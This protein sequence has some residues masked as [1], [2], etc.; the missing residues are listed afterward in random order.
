MQTPTHNRFNLKH[1]YE[2]KPF[3][4]TL[5]VAARIISVNLPTNHPL[6]IFQLWPIDLL[7]TRLL[8]E[9]SSPNIRTRTSW[10]IQATDVHFTNCICPFRILSAHPYDKWIIR[11]AI[12]LVAT[13][14]ER[15][16]RRMLRVFPKTH[17]Q[18]LELPSVY[19]CRSRFR[20]WLPEAVIW[21]SCCKQLHIQC[22]HLREEIKFRVVFAR[23]WGFSSVII[24]WEK[25]VKK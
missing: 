10:T 3:K 12:W 5:E 23:A 21:L 17:T 14:C 2:R 22:W 8:I 9:L 18:I 11:K 24:V 20:R 4:L 19:L 1:S 25:N 15:Y 7:I 6:F 13:S 16:N